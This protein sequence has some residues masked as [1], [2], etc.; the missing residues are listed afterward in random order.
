LYI[1]PFIYMYIF[2]PMVLISIQMLFITRYI[3]PVFRARFVFLSLDDL[4]HFFFSRRRLL[5]SGGRAI[6]SSIRLG[7]PLTQRSPS[8]LLLLYV[9]SFISCRHWDRRGTPAASSSTW[10]V[11][12]TIQSKDLPAASSATAGTDGALPSPDLIR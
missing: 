4:L 1:S 7:S 5:L 2:G 9:R 10:E 8:S 11:T 6:S 3:E 12:V